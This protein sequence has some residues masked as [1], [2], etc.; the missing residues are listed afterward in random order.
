MKHKKIILIGL[1]TIFFAASYTWAAKVDAPAPPAGTEPGAGVIEGDYPPPPKAT[2]DLTMEEAMDYVMSI[3]E[4]IH[5]EPGLTEDEKQAKALD[6]IENFRYGEDELQYFWVNNV[7]GIMLRHPLNPTLNG[8]VVT[9]IRDPKGTLVF[10]EMIQTALE[11]GRGYVHYLWDKPGEEFSKPK[12][13]L[14]QLFAPYSW[15]IGT[16]LYLVVIEE[17]EEPEPE[18]PIVTYVDDRDPASPF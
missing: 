16:G 17:Y 11:Q 8:Q 2:Y 15:V 7:Q 10:V 1:L 13:S 6:F 5:N 12:E 4:S 18:A 3:V 14:V 9:T